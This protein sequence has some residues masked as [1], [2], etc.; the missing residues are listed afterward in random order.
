MHSCNLID[1]IAVLNDFL[2]ET[3]Q[4]TQGD[5]KS[6]ITRYTNTARPSEKAQNAQITRQI[7][8]ASKP[9]RAIFF[10]T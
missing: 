6:K 9:C 7:G 10:T 8:D 5:L 4:A 2:A 1:F 3:Q